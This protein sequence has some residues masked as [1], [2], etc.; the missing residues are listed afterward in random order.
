MQHKRDRSYGRLKIIV[1]G[2]HCI[3]SSER[4]LVL[5]TF[6]FQDEVPAMELNWRRMSMRVIDVDP[7]DKQFDE[8]SV[9]RV[10][11]ALPVSLR[12]TYVVII[13]RS[14]VAA[15]SNVDAHRTAGR[16]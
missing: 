13:L 6:E 10:Q 14:G 15:F 4:V 11:M 3:E 16:R 7:G 5:L 9:R 8:G 1:C 12:S 2:R